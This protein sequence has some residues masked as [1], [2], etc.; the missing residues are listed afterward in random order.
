MQILYRKP[1]KEKFSGIGKVVLKK[2]RIVILLPFECLLSYK[3]SEKSE[4]NFAFLIQKMPLL[5]LL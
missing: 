2:F 3:L 1:S 4:T 5:T